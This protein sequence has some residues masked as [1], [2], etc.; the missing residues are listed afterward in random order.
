M[1]KRI[2]LVLLVISL[3]LLMMPTV[4]ASGITNVKSPESMDESTADR[5]SDYVGSNTYIDNTN[6]IELSDINDSPRVLLIE[7]TDPW[8]STA[9]QTVLSN[10]TK[11]DKVS[12][13]NFLD[14]DLS[15]YNVIVFANDQTL[16]AYENYKDIKNYLETFARLGGVIV[17]GACDNGWSDG[18]LNEKLPGG[19]GK[20]NVYAP[21]NYVADPTHPIVTGELTDNLVLTD[22]DLYGN[23]CSHIVFDESTLP[24]ETNVILREKE[25]NLPTLIEYPLGQGKIIASGLT[26]E[27]NYVNANAFARKSMDDLYTYAVSICKNGSIIDSNS[28]SDGAPQIISAKI[29]YKGTKYDLFSKAITIEKDSNIKASIEAT[30]E[31]NGCENVK[32]YVTQGVGKETDITGVCKDF[33]PG[34]DFSAGKD[35]YILAVDEKTGKSTSK[36]T[37]LKVSSSKDGSLGAA[38]GVEG[39]NFKFGKDVGFTIPDS[40]PVFGGTEI[41]W[42]FDFIPITFEYDKEDDNKLNIVIGG[43]VISE[44]YEK[45]GVKRKYFKN[46]D[47]KKYKK[48]ISHAARTQRHDLKDLRKYFDKDKGKKKNM[49][50]FGGAVSGSGK[51]GTGGDIDFMGYAEMKYIDGQWKFVEGVIKLDAEIKY[52]YEGQIFIWVVPCYYEFGGGVGAGFEGKMIDLNPDSFTPKFEGYLSAKILAEIGGG[53]G[54]SGVATAGASGEGSLNLKTALERKYIKSWGEGSASFHVKLFGKT[55]AEKEFARGDFLIYET[56]SNKGLIKDKNGIELSSLDEPYEAIDINSV[57][58]NESRAYAKNP[59][60]WRGSEPK[61]NL[62]TAD[63][64]NKDLKLLAENVYTESAPQICEIDGKKVMIT[65]WDNTNRADIDRTMLVYSVYDVKS[66]TWSKP[67]AVDDDGTAD[68]Y[69][70]FKDGYLVWQNSKTT[71]SDNMTL[72]EIAQTGEI[73]AAKWNGSGFDKPIAITNNNSLDTLPMAAATEDG[74]SVVWVTNTEDDILGITGKNSIMRADFDGKSWS[75]SKVVKND[76]NAITNITAG[77]VNDKFCVAYVADDDNDLNTI[78]DRDIRIINDAGETQ[79]TDNDILDSN[80][81]FAGNMIYYYSG[82]NIAYSNINGSNTQT[83][84]SE[85]KPGLTDAFDVDSKGRNRAIWWTKSE[86][87]GAEVYSSL[88]T[89]GAWS[90]E[91]KI[92]DVGN[93]AKYP[94]GI[95]NDDGSMVVAF[96]NGIL[97]NNEI[98]KTDLYTVSVNPSYDL[99]LTDAYIDEDTMTV[100]ATVTNCGELTVD[101]YKLT[102]NDNGVNAAK[103][104]IKPLK[105]GESAEIEIVYNKPKS[106]TEHDFEVAVA[107]IY[108]DEYNSQNN[109]AMLSVGHADISVDNVDVNVDEGKITADISNIGY[110]DAQNVTVLLRENSADGTVIDEQ[111]VDVGVNETNSVEF[112]FGKS[113]MRFY[114]STKQFYIT[115]EY[116]GEEASVGNNDGYAVFT[117]PSGAADYQTELLSYDNIDGQYMINSVA[118]NNTD[119]DLTCQIYTAV[120]SADGVLKDCGTVD[121]AIAANDDTGVDICVSCELESGD[122]IKTFMWKNQEPLCNAAEMVIEP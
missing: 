15:N 62:M 99:E 29:T 43:N 25:T 1:K 115:A 72:K 20:M 107:T 67:A 91:I 105:A 23:F 65:Q 27:H 51:G 90:D 36:R 12:T 2:L 40:V 111:T 102:I 93:M 112:T 78:N 49:N 101:L 50:L 73:C 103:T 75:A 96:N 5:P 117:S 14:V 55:V 60:E 79:L 16:Y 38:S 64:T 31:N 83:V 88:Y 61:V 11:Y 54:I 74:A 53:I 52:T 6:N 4:L 32:V 37:K 7:N 30:V 22:N 97:E 24:K 57:Y 34:K 82:G 76:L 44:E 10:I 84:F 110:T 48:D 89:D 98:V 63:Y 47:F 120:Y 95:L 28:T 80:P 35:I 58:E 8:D 104:I 3:S 87:G 39:L 119:A 45:N 33:T 70:C 122:T 13:V 77:T 100:Y 66:G 9:N 18:Q 121:A 46:L 69:P 85:A 71:L 113:A 114:D 42:S 59:T 81:V 109:S 94:S 56:G 116:G 68:F 21:Y 106:L 86:N 41:N 26:W 17:F 108:G 92:T 118:V 19:V